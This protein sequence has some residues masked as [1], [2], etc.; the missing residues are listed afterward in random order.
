MLWDNREEILKYLELRY[1]TSEAVLNR[2]GA[3][4]KGAQSAKTLSDNFA[5]GKK[6]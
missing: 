1:R 5:K 2:L 6:P 4:L 3:G